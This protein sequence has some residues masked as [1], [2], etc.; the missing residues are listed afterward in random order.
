MLQINVNMSDSDESRI[1]R[2]PR[3]TQM[4]FA[5][6][7]RGKKNKKRTVLK[8][9]K[10]EERTKKPIQ[11][12][13]VQPVRFSI[14]ASTAE[15][16][17]DEKSDSGESNISSGS[18]IEHAGDN[19][20]TFAV[21]DRLKISSEPQ[22]TASCTDSGEKCVSRVNSAGAASFMFSAYLP[23]SSLFWFRR[24]LSRKDIALQ[25]YSNAN[26]YRTPQGM[27]LYV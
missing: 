23:F 12:F 27:L 11:G 2:G 16:F 1:M 8:M 6:L 9:E 14:T 22:R 26:A 13:L 10:R 19:P 4:V 17:K 3:S 7:A 24:W 20:A 5:A 21:V 15:K 25:Y 18:E